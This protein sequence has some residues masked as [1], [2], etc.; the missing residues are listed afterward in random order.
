MISSGVGI[1]CIIIDLTASVIFFRDRRGV[2]A[3]L[4]VVGERHNERGLVF[5]LIG[6]IYSGWILVIFFIEVRLR[7]FVVFIYR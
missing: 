3:R 1:L 6:A 5:V 2:M 4:V 7:C